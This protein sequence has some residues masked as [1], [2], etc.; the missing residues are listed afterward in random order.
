MWSDDD[1]RVAAP[2]RARAPYPTCYRKNPRAGSPDSSLGPSGPPSFPF[3]PSPRQGPPISQA[4]AS[5]VGETAPSVLVSSQSDVDDIETGDR[6]RYLPGAACVLC[7]AACSGETEPGAEYTYRL[8][9]FIPEHMQTRFAEESI[10]FAPV[11]TPRLELTH[12]I[13]A[14]ILQLMTKSALNDA[15]E[16]SGLPPQESLHLAMHKARDERL[17]TPC[18]FRYF[19]SLNLEGNAGK[20]KP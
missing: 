9:D 20:H 14:F 12:R 19:L 7:G 5:S 6:P 15:L 18:E 2:K 1:G 11:A 16:F 8:V 3:S 10:I 4:S 17:I 13:Y